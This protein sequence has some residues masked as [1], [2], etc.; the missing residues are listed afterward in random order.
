MFKRI[1]KRRMEGPLILW[2]GTQVPYNELPS[3]TGGSLGA[4][5]IP[6]NC[7]SS[8]GILFEEPYGQAARGPHISFSHWF[9]IN[10]RVLLRK[11]GTLYKPGEAMDDDAKVKEAMSAFL[12][13]EISDYYHIWTAIMK[14]QGK[15]FVVYDDSVL[16]KAI[17]VLGINVI[18]IVQH[19]ERRSRMDM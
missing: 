9:Q 1:E 15:S 17:K 5:V 19:P 8:L 12:Q 10:L 3:I 11:D 6:R 18:P 2:N 4:L 16:G 14:E 7:Y 13:R